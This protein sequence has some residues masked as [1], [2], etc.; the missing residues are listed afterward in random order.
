MPKL[1]DT[2]IEIYSVG[3]RKIWVKREDQACPSPG[4]PFS[5]VRGLVPALEKLSS[6]GIFT[7]GYTETSIS[8]AGWGVA[9]ACKKLGM[10]AVIFDPQYKNT[11]ALLKYHRK[12]WKQFGPE[13][14]PIKAGMA[15][16]NYFISKKILKDNYSNSWLLPLGLVLPETIEATQQVA[17]KLKD[18]FNTIVVNVGS[19]TICSGLLKAFTNH[20]VIGVMGRTGDVQ[21]KRQM[22]LS[23]AKLQDGGM[24]GIKGF[25]LVDPGWHYTDPCHIKSPFPTH[26]YYDAKAWHWLCQNLDVLDDPILFWNIGR[27]H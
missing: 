7:V 8:M 16:V 10:K 9:W 14:I 18:D 5:K 27:V 6:K 20:K 17:M 21:R 3:D 11:P 4:P 22:I 24:F 1:I 23:K 13:I 2:P 15:K 25:D 26:L 19:G 12:Q